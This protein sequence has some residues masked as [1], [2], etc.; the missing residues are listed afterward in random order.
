MGRRH[1][2]CAGRRNLDVQPGV[3]KFVDVYQQ[4]RE[5]KRSVR[6]RVWRRHLR[7]LRSIV[8]LDVQQEQRSAHCRGRLRG[9]WGDLREHGC[10][11]VREDSTANTTTSA[12]AGN[13]YGG[14]IVAY[15]VFAYSST[16]AGN[17]ASNG[18]NI[19]SAEI[20]SYGSA[21]V[22]AIGDGNCYSGTSATSYGY[23]FDDDGTCFP[24]SGTDFGDGVNPKLGKL[25]DNG[26]PTKTMLPATGSPLIDAATDG[27]C[28]A[29]HASDA[30]FTPDTDQR[31]IA[32]PGATC[33]IGAVETL[34]D[35]TFTIDT[36]HGII[37]G[38][39][40]NGTGVSANAYVD[41][42]TLGTP[43]STAVFPYGGIPRSRSTCPPMAG[44]SPSSLSCPR[45]STSCGSSTIPRG[46][47]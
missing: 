7:R 41:P 23:N 45:T 20:T 28:V 6:L 5:R 36:G 33:D 31:G 18:G 25:K 26:G 44:P 12:T 27:E 35:L 21:I 9:C 1:V 3:G 40:I 47:R 13:T 2:G 17:T 38:T 24:T 8:I 29:G 42:G 43:P 46:P 22:G 16:I 34:A 14:A 39:V 15:G 37:Y 11:R 10:V 30:G 19:D 32:R 4:Q